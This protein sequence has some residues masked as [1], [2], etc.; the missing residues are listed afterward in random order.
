MMEEDNKFC[1]G[2]DVYYVQYLPG[3]IKC[4]KA[5][6]IIKLIGKNALAKEQGALFSREYILHPEDIGETVFFQIDDV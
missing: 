5:V 2:K 6:K 1:V 3:N 4:I